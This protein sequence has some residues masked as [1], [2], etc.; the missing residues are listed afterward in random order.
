MEGDTNP[1][2]YLSHNSPIKSF[3]LLK[4]VAYNV[5]LGKYIHAKSVVTSFLIYFSLILLAYDFIAFI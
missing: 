4:A 3:P 1:T 5:S 2:L